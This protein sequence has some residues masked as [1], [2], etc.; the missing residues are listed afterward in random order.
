MPPDKQQPRLLFRLVT[1]KLARVPMAFSRESL[2]QTWI[3]EWKPVRVKRMR[4]YTAGFSCARLYLG[5]A[6]G[7]NLA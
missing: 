2:P 6:I 7:R 4:Q 1:R 3:A 5:A